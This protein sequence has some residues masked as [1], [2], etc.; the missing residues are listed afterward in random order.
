M[1][2]KP[3]VYQEH[4]SKFEVRAWP[5][6]KPDKD[7]RSIGVKHS[8]ISQIA[9]HQEMQPALKK[10]ASRYGELDHPYLVALNAVGTFHNED[11]VLD[12]LLGTP[13]VEISK[14]GRRRGNRQASSQAGRHLVWSDR[15]SKQAI[16][17]GPGPDA[18]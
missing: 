6:N 18:H 2:A 4:G 1:Q 11:A 10:K 14:R 13:Y 8:P 16:E 12:A 7:G 17:R 15:D 9:P 3:F 5:R